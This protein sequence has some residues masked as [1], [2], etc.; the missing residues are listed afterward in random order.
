MRIAFA[1]VALLLASLLGAGIA[2]PADHT[3]SAVAQQ[4]G[5]LHIHADVV[6][7]ELGARLC[8]LESRY[9][10]GEKVVFRARVVD[11][12]TGEMA[13]NAEVVVR[14]ADGTTL[15]MHLSGHPPRGTP[16]DEFWA[17]GWVVPDDAPMGVVRYSIEAVDGPRSVRFEPFNVE[18]SLLTIVPAS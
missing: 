1:I 13:P 5:G 14:F 16:T 4:A 12:R 8:A 6:T 9:A 18:T 11:A 2:A 15:P 3:P 10:P 17:V 7:G